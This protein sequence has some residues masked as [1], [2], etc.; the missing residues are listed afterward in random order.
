M[1]NAYF[2]KEPLI[3]IIV[4]SS[5]DIIIQGKCSNLAARDIC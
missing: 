3:K 4:S 1:F 5:S 2:K